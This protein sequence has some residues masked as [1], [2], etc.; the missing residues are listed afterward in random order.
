MSKYKIIVNPISGRG[1]G[2]LSIHQIHNYL[3]NANIKYDLVTTSSPGH[4]IDLAQEA[5]HN[6]YDIVVAVG[7]DGTANEVI[8]GLMKARKLYGYCSAMGVI[9]VG[10]GNDFAFGAEIPPGVEAGC[11]TLIHCTKKLIDVGLVIGGDYPEGRYFGNGIG[12]GFDTVVGFEA[13]K[14]TWLSGFPSYIAAVLKTVFL[15][16]NA[17]LI[18][19][20]YDLQSIEKPSIMISIMNGKRMGGGFLMAPKAQNDDGFL[21]ICLVEQVS[22]SRIFSL[23]PYFLKGTQETQKEIHTYTAKKLQISA[24]NGSL[25]VH[26]DG[27]TICVAGGQLDIE[28]LPKQIEIVCQHAR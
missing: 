27:E 3:T 6:G 5:S 11:E 1:Q 12:I 9:S 10:R 20:N 13:V 2:N 7:G 25:P 18:R 17:P 26:A 28:L 23:I 16:F 15:Y 19:M 14:L 8:N 4:A 21:N 24:I 22:R